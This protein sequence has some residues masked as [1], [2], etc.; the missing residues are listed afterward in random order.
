MDDFSVYSDSFDKCLENLALV[1]KGIVLGHVISSRGIEVDK[2][3]I[4][5]MHFLPPPTNTPKKVYLFNLAPKKI[6]C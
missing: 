2:S 1:L 5:I 4:D 6:S 3:K